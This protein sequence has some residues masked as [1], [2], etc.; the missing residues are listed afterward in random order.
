[1]S[2]SIEP[3]NKICYFEKPSKPLGPQPEDVK[4]IEARDAKKATTLLTSEVKGSGKLVDGPNRTFAIKEEA[5][6]K[7]TVN[8]DGQ[9]LGELINVSA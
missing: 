4:S 5:S 1:M 2:S 6:L 3:S 9:S 7:P 8:T